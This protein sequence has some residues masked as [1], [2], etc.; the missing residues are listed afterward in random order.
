MKELL[1][2]LLLLASMLVYGQEEKTAVEYSKNIETKV[3]SLKY[4]VNATKDFDMF[5]WSA[6][7]SIFE[8]NKPDQEV[9]LTFE[10]DLKE[11]KNKFKGS[12]TVSGETKNID[13]LI[14]KAKKNVKSLIKNFKKHENE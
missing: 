8:T 7:K 10:I 2:S 13:S 14:E 3:T 6:I 5:D 4:S 12:I 11:S 1:T 9:A